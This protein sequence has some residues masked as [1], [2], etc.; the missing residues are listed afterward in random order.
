MLWQLIR[1]P[2]KEATDPMFRPLFGL[3]ALLITVGGIVYRRIEKWSLL[4][5]C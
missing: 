3:I 4:D 1:S 5:S 2:W